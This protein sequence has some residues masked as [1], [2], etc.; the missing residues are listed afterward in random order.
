[1]KK[2]LILLG[3]SLSL[4]ACNSASDTSD[5]TEAQTDVSEESTGEE[6]EKEVTE[7]ETSD[8]ESAKEQTTEEIEDV[9]IT[10][11]YVSPQWAKAA[12]DGK[13]KGY[14][15]LF[16][17]EVGWG[18][19]KDSPYAEVGYIPGSVHIN[20]DLFEEGPV[21]NFKSSEDVEKA[22]LSLG[23]DKDTKVLLYGKGAGGVGRV[24]LACLWMGVEDVKIVDGSVENW[25]VAG[26]DLEKEP[27]EAVAKEEFGIEVPAKPELVISTDQT[28]EELANNDNF[29]LI[30]IR[31]Y[32]E[33]IGETS[34]YSYIDKAGEPEGAVWGKDVGDY[35]NDDGTVKSLDEMIAMWKENDLDY[36]IDNDLAYYCGTGWRAAVPI[37]VM[38]QNG[39]DN[40]TLYD[41]GWNE[42]QMDPEN[43]VQVG[44]PAK[45]DV[46]ITTV[47]EL[48]DG[49]AVE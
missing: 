48:P 44:D 32:E 15:E 7:E 14:E 22:L 45:G 9:S 41:G 39:L 31:S 11:V 49:K 13:V 6:T 4:V 33:F 42:W 23:I 30:S 36:S 12:I 25:Q 35:M 16:V 8:T 3:L 18:E 37:L 20:T 10:T 24:A 5:V 26:Y 29:K 2:L 21:W 27:V 34:G 47:K 46:E 43:P 38:Y 1:M 17:G 28:K 40:M 19:V